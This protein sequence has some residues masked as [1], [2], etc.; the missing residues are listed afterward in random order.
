MNLGD[1]ISNF[2]KTNY[3]EGYAF[4]IIIIC[5]IIFFIFIIIKNLSYHIL[6]EDLVKDT[7]K[8][9]IN[10]EYLIQLK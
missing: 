3:S 8:Q 2:N 5:L 1:K 9:L 6:Y 7:I 4:F 10:S